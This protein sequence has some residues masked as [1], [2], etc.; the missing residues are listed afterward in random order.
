MVDDAQDAV[1]EQLG[2]VVVTSQDAS[3]EAVQHVSADNAVLIYVNQAGCVVDLGGELHALLDDNDIAG[4]GFGSLVDHVDHG[5]GLAGALGSN[6]QFQHRGYLLVF[7][8]RH[9]PGVYSISLSGWL[10]VRPCGPRNRACPAGR[11]CSSCS[12]QRRAGQRG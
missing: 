11:T 12:S 10:P 8:R 4:S 2:D 6:D 9:I 5:F 7:V 1:D 3:H